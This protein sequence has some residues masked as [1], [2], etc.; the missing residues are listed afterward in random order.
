MGELVEH[1]V[2]TALREAGAARHRRPRQQHRT[3]IGRLTEQRLWSRHPHPGDVVGAVTAQHDGALVDD[4][5]RDARE[6]VA[7]EAQQQQ[8]CLGGDEQALL[9]V[10]RAAARR[11][12]AGFTHEPDDEFVQSCPLDG[13][14]LAPLGEPG[15]EDGLPVAP[16]SSTLRRPIGDGAT[17]AVP[18][19]EPAVTR[20]A[21]QPRRWRRRRISS[22]V[23]LDLWHT[24]VERDPVVFRNIATRW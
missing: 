20:R 23:N 10:E 21:P 12:P 3:A 6:A 24:R 19:H 4:D 15:L 5:R 17:R 22:Y 1:D 11:L 9:V 2:V 7:I 14:E 18:C 13:I 16:A 8:A